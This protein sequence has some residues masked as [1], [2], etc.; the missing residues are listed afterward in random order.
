MKILFYVNDVFVFSRRIEA[1][2]KDT[3]NFPSGLLSCM[4]HRILALMIGTLLFYRFFMMSV[5]RLCPLV[6]PIF[7]LKR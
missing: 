3:I 7:L 4:R 1:Y 6:P 5:V 2:S